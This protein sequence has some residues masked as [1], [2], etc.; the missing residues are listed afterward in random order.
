MVCMPSAIV[1]RRR[2]WSRCWRRGRR[3]VSPC[4]AAPDSPAVMKTLEGALGRAGY[5]WS[6]SPCIQRT[7]REEIA[8]EVRT[9]TIRH[10]RRLPL[11]ALGMVALLTGLWAGLARLGWDVPVPRQ[12]FSVLHGP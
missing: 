6:R 7:S 11:L 4:H 9:M 12:E 10:P 1:C 2:R 3:P 8:E 5:A